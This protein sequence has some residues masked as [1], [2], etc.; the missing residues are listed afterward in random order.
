MQTWNGIP[1]DTIDVRIR[2]GRPMARCCDNNIFKERNLRRVPCTGDDDDDD[3]SAVKAS[4]WNCFSQTQLITL[5]DSLIN[6]IE[7]I[8]PI[9]NIGVKI[10]MTFETSALWNCIKC[11]HFAKR[12]VQLTYD[13]SKNAMGTS[14]FLF[15]AVYVVSDHALIE[16]RLIRVQHC[17]WW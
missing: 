2:Q 14:G 12:W 17:I 7:T 15:A 3:V 11:W 5:V 13:G 8:F 10:K 16:Q 4:S 6:H 1:Y 9:G